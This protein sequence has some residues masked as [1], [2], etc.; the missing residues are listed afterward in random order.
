[1]KLHPAPYRNTGSPT[2]N[3]TSRAPNRKTRAAA[4]RFTA[5]DRANHSRTLREAFALPNSCGKRVQTSTK[6]PASIAAINHSA[7][8]NPTA[9]SSAPPTKNPIPLVAFFE[10]VNQATQ[11]NNCPAPSCAVALIALL[12]AVLVRS[13]AMPHS[14]CAPTTQAT[15]NAAPQPGSSPD[16]STNPAIC[17]PMPQANMRGMPKRTASQ[18]PIALV[19]MPAASYSRNRLASMNGV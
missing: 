19:T 16:S 12:A 7:G 2:T 5:G 3:Q 14:P 6:T 9:C 10:P 13:L 8:R 1:M 15:D 18:P 11:R 17:T 4:S